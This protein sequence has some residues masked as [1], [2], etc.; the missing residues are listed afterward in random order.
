MFSYLSDPRNLI[1]ANHKRP[2]VEQSDPP[3]G[4]GSWFVLSL[5]QLRARVEYTVYEPTRRIAATV[6][7]WGRGSGGA[8]SEHEFELSELDGGSRTRIDAHMDGH[9]GLIRWAPLRRVTD[10]LL[11]WRMRR[12]IERSA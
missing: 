7:W 10:A 5:D 11:R 2:I 4:A 1:A 12:R 6:T 8:S 9:G 3:L